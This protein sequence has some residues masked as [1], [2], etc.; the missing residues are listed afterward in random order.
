MINPSR[1]E[2]GVGERLGPLECL[3]AARHVRSTAAGRRAYDRL[4]PRGV[5]GVLRD[6]APLWLLLYRAGLESRVI[7]Q[8]PEGFALLEPPWARP[9]SRWQRGGVR[10]LALRTLE[11]YWGQIVFAAPALVLISSA[12]PLALVT[13]SQLAPVIPVLLGMIYIV[14][15]LTIM[16]SWQI[17]FGRSDERPGPTVPDLAA[18]HW[19]MPL[20]HQEHD[21]RVDELFHRIERRMRQLV[22]LNVRRNATDQGG[23]V[24][25]VR[26]TGRLIYPLGAATSQALEHRILEARSVR[27]SDHSMLLFD[28]R[29]DDPPRSPTAALPFFRF[30]VAASLVVVFAL[31]FFVTVFERS[32]CARGCVGGAQTY[33]R[34]LIWI[35]YRLVWQD[36]PGIHPASSATVAFGALFA[37][38]I[39]MIAL[40]GGFALWRRHRVAANLER[41]EDDRRKQIMGK[42]RV[43]IVTVA[44]I[45]RTVMLETLEKYTRRAP[46][47]DFTSQVP[48]FSMGTVNDA[49]LYVVQA[50]SQGSG[51]GAGA[52]SV[53]ANAVRQLDP[54]Y[55]VIAGICYGLRPAEQQFGDILVSERIRDLDHGKLVELD[56]RI[57]EQ[58]RGETVVPSGMLLTAVRAAAY[59]W[60]R[61]SAAPV[62]IGL[63]L[64][65]NKLVNAEPVVAEL[66]ARHPDAIGGDMEGMG[67][68]AA[69]R[70]GGVECILVKGICD[71]AAKKD[72]DAQPVAARNAAEFVLHL[73]IAG[74]FSTTPRDKRG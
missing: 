58:L 38:L 70:L 12:L 43:L 47:L 53:T 32:A 51:G 62:R 39:P 7:W 44:D 10:M 57:E 11:R 13:R 3:A 69:A 45:E 37:L 18:E 55:A 54:H 27:N 61:G 64:A 2:E 72:D 66:R 28:A 34:A 73:I 68:H 8:D 21:E 24:G 63:M 42:T 16:A 33:D 14:V 26:L 56:G 50:G 59:T 65:W 15:I 25:P 35:A 31:T 36:A 41:I 23:H 4:R 52:L 5:T 48:V 40:V 71:F 20:A 9:S 29:S 67:F 49:D 6:R 17:F 1:D 19:S 60:Q 46:Q 74:V 22:A 30:Y